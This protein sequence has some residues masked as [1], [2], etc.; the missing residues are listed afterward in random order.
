MI[1]SYHHMI[2]SVSPAT[3]LGRGE[4]RSIGSLARRLASWLRAV[5]RRPGP[6]GPRPIALPAP[7]LLPG[8]VALAHWG[9]GGTQLDPRLELL[10]AQ[11]SA[12]LSTCRWC[13]D[14]GRHRW[15]KAFLPAGLLRHLRGCRT[16]TLF[17]ERECAALVL[18]EA[19]ACYTDRDPVAA[20]SALARARSH[21]TESEVARIAQLAAGE[22]FFD[23]ATGAVGQDVAGGPGA[24]KTCHAGPGMP[25]E[26]IGVG[27]SI[28]GWS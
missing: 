19:V 23:P 25:W 2:N 9:P 10:V 20:D 18:A 28:R 27:I 4:A 6:V 11:L 21:F 15:R 17:S 12:E 24:A 5:G 14:Q 16:S 13:I 1:Q 3:A 8:Y 22:H 7:G 26:S